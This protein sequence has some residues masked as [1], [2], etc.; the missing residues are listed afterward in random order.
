MKNPNFFK[1]KLEAMYTI[2][3]PKVVSF[4][5]KQPDFIWKDLPEILSEK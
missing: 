2:W 5:I 1:E 3:N 4:A